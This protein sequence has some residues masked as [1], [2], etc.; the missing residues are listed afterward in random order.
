M[1]FKLY[2]M[3][4]FNLRAGFFGCGGANFMLCLLM[5]YVNIRNV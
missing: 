1:V 5:L 2:L 4:R 3:S